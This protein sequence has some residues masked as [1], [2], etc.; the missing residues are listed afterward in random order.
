MKNG[1]ALNSEITNNFN[2]IWH[3]ANVEF[4][5]IYNSTPFNSTPL[6][7]SFYNYTMKRPNI[8][9]PSIFNIIRDSS[10]WNKVSDKWY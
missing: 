8:S 10:K 5:E 3:M 2:N 6:I 7:G 9:T 4:L 1:K